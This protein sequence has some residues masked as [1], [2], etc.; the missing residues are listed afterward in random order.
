MWS[1][2]PPARRS[3]QRMLEA[4]NAT[5]SVA[6]RVI[7]DAPLENAHA[8]PRCLGGQDIQLTAE[9]RRQLAQVLKVDSEE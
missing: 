4:H 5:L 2:A 9:S 1:A 6:W 7:R 3:L 8:G